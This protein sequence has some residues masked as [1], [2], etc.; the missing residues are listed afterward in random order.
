LLKAKLRLREAKLDV[1]LGA[2]PSVSPFDMR[3]PVGEAGVMLSAFMRSFINDA[4]LCCEQIGQQAALLWVGA[5][6]SPLLLQPGPELLA[7]PSAA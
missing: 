7:V 4:E 5:T 1:N 3:N 2:M 6:R